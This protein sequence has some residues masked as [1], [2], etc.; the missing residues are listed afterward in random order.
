MGDVVL[1]ETTDR[2]CTITLHRPEARNALNTALHRASGRALAD[3]EADVDVVVLTG[4]DP[5][6]GAGLDLK[7]LG[8]GGTTLRVGAA[9]S[10]SMTVGATRW[11][12]C[13]P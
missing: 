3:A 2:V 8:A 12:R 6:F 1:V 4:A 13:G 5:A 11:K 9:T 7:E 10:T